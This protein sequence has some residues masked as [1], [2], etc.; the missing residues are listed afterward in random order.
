MNIYFTKNDQN[1]ETCTT[2]FAKIFT[3][4]PIEK[5]I[6]CFRWECE[7][8]YVAELLKQFLS[9]EFNK[10]VSGIR[11]IAYESGWKDAKSKSKK[12]TEFNISFHLDNFVGI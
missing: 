12:K 2:V 10:T 6:L 7:S 9:E 3:D 5:S 4:L 11:K 8:Q 1:P